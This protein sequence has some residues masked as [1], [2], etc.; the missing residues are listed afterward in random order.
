MQISAKLFPF[1]AKIEDIS[2]K[3]LKIEKFSAFKILN[4]YSQYLKNILNKYELASKIEEYLI[5][6][7]QRLKDK[8]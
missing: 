6:L 2:H 7:S 8:Q 3:Q 4:L 1:K 5:V